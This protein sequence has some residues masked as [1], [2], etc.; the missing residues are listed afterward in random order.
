MNNKKRRVKQLI[1]LL[2]LA[3]F[4][5]A[6]VY[7]QDDK[8][9]VAEKTETLATDNNAQ[10]IDLANEVDAQQTP[11]CTF[12]N[13]CINKTIARV[14]QNKPHHVSTQ[15]QPKTYK[16]IMG[17][18]W[19][20]NQC[21]IEVDTDSVQQV[22]QMIEQLNNEFTLT[23]ASYNVTKHLILSITSPTLP[24]GFS[25][26][27]ANKIKILLEKYEYSF[28]LY[29][30]KNIE[31][32]IVILPSKESYLDFI[33]SLSLDNPYSQG[34]YWARSNYAFVA[35][36]NAK[37]AAQTA[38]HESVHAIN[39]SLVGLQSRWINE[40]LA[41]LFESMEINETDKGYTASFN[42]QRPMSDFTALDYVDL[43]Y[44]EDQWDTEQRDELYT[45]ARNF[46]TYLVTQ[47][48]GIQVVSSLLQEERRDPCSKLS[49]D[50]YIQLI[51][52]NVYDMQFGYEDWLNANM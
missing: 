15:Q 48:Q 52:D 12:D 6:T 42:I 39:F 27:L 29:L 30:K 31:I 36:K 2:I 34:L 1:L 38:F 10:T 9:V 40:G 20:V 11:S 16:K 32:N 28:G 43:L 14:K 7:M 37:Q 25:E 8:V 3:V 47:P 50:S 5:V 45:N 41:E 26:T 13:N 33:A 23:K 19:D 49:E 4:S 46:L 17:L 21:R 35:F 22:N 24:T 51:E 18:P 44:S